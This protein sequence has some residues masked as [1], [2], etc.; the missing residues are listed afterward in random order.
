MRNYVE[1]NQQLAPKS[2]GAMIPRTTAGLWLRNR[3]LGLVPLLR[4][5]R[6][7]LEAG[8]QR[9]ANSLTLAALPSHLS[10]SRLPAE[11]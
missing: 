9:A 10:V 5:L 4:R 6:L 11:R 7:P 2:S 8:L 3:M 1:Q